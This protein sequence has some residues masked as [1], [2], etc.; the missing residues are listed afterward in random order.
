[1]LTQEWLQNEWHHSIRRWGRTYEVLYIHREEL[2][3]WT[4]IP[5]QYTVTVLIED[6]TQRYTSWF[7]A[8]FLKNPQTVAS[9]AAKVSRPPASSPDIRRHMVSTQPN[10]QDTTW[11]SPTVDKIGKVKAKGESEQRTSTK[12]THRVRTG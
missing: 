6:S 5:Q 2:D 3:Q 4:T 8:G 10:T 1:M 9:T 12:H 11:M 7:R